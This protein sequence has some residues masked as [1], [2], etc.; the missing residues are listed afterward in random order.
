MTIQN[1]FS[2]AAGRFLPLAL[3]AVLGIFQASC[4][5]REFNKASA[6]ADGHSPYIEDDFESEPTVGELSNGCSHA[7][8]AQISQVNLGAAK[9]EVFLKQCIVETKSQKYCA[10]VARPN[11]DSHSTFD[12][13]YSISQ[14]HTF[15]HPD[16]KTWKYAIEAVKL[17]QELE[18]KGIKV[19]NIYNWWRPEPYN[20]NVGGAAGRHP[21]GTSVD[22]RFA[23]KTE[24]NRAQKELC[25]YRA[26]GRLRAVGYYSGTGLHLGVGDRAANTWGK[27]CSS[28]FNS[29]ASADHVH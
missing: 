25:K 28:S 4:S 20:K 12:C 16:E 23:S 24:Q 22:V 8:A 19:V 3:I 17:V 1:A 27:S 9:R 11:P 21:F 18:A 29:A 10:Q 15:V 26:Q 13:T 6:E 14:A 2:N 5:E 7:T